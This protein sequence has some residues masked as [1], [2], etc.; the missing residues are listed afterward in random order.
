MTLAPD[1]TVILPVYNE[2]ES[3]G[4]LWAE[5]EPALGRLARKAEVLVVDDGSTD[6]SAA[7]VRGL[8]RG[9]ERVRLVRLGRNAGLTAAL[10][11]GFAAARGEIVVTMD[12]DLQYHPDDIVPLVGLTDR[13]DAALGYRGRREDPWLKRISSRIANGVRTAVL[14]DEVRD[15]ACTLRAMHREC[16][17]AIAPYHGMHRFVPTLLKQAGFRVTEVEVRHRPRRHGESKYGVRNRTFR[18]FADLLAVR[19]MRARRVVYDV[20]EDTARQ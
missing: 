14:R 3:L 13:F 5:L 10:L 1:V 12:S 2:V 4:P 15:S 17:R 18:A 11:A 9:D 16:L 7:F 6:G 20:V 8:A 19:W